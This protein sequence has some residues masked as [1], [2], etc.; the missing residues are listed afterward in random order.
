MNNVYLVQVDVASGSENKT[1]YLPYAAGLLAAYAWEDPVINQYY[2]FKNFVYKRDNI[3]DVLNNMENPGVVGFSNY[4]WNTEYNKALA[5]LIKTAYPNCIII[6]GGH[7]VPDSTSMLLENDY[8]DILIHGEGERAFKSTLLALSCRKSLIDVCN[9]SFRNQAGSIIKNPTSFPGQL[10][11]LPSPYLEGWFDEI[12]NETINIKFNAI[13]ETSR[14]C[15]NQCAY[16]DWG[17]LNSKTRIFPLERV[18]AEIDWISQHKISFLW[19]ADANFGM[20]S[21]DLPIVEALVQAKEKTGFPEKMRMSYSK[22]N[23]ENVFSISRKLKEFDFDRNGVTLS[24][25]SFSPVVLE[26]IGRKNMSFD[27]FNELLKR[28]NKENIRTY[29]ELILGLPGETIESFQD[30]VGKLLELGQH[31]LIEIYGCILLPNSAMGQKEFVDKFGIE[32]VRTEM[33]RYHFE[34]EQFDIIEYNDLVVSTNAM[35]ISDWIKCTVFG[36]MVKAMHCDGILRAFAIYLFYEKQVPYQLFYNKLLCFFENNPGYHSSKI[37]FELTT[38]AEKVAKGKNYPPM[39]FKPCGNITWNDDEYAILRL[40]Y[41]KDAFF[42]EI[43]PFLKS[44]DIDHVLF[45]DL[46]SYQKGVLREPSIEET[47]MTL[48]YDLHSYFE[49]IYRGS[50]KS[51]E[52]KNNTLKLTDTMVTKS[53]IEYGKNIVWYGKFGC[54]FYKDRA[55]IKYQHNKNSDGT[56]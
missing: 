19:G 47:T 1:I 8:I 21:R 48:E 18:L 20:F 34:P 55:K 38:H 56:T 33:P 45:E 53:W 4:C 3:Y 36:S 16:C 50:A 43:I 13:F 17:L 42:A 11:D 39:V 46:L 29:S 12:V 7:N 24:F 44:F 10:D 15:P 51:L 35:S 31:Y 54:N 52:K 37:Y 23:T 25:Q 49:S 5:G 9:I 32:T 28:Y 26:N 6:F 14:G 2:S 27:F 40:L 41:L 22:S 30:G